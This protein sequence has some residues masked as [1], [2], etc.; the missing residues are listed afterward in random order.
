MN[1]A[2]AGSDD[3]LPVLLLHGFPF[4][5]RMWQPQL[6]AL[7]HSFRLIAPDTRGSG[8]SET[9]DAEYTMELL[10]D[11]VLAILDALGI[12]RAVGCGLSMGGYVLLRALERAPE[13]FTGAVLCDTK[14]SAD[15]DEG[16]QAR[17]S[18][19]GLIRQRGLEHFAEELLP[20]VMA[21][22]TLDCRPEL[23][24]GVRSMIL[25]N[26]EEGIIGLQ[27]AMTGRTDTTP[28]LEELSIPCLIVVG[29]HDELT[30]PDVARSMA[31]RIT[32]AF[33]VQI[34]GAGHLS[35]LEDPEAFNQA[36]TE[37]LERV[38]AL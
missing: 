28:V 23:V 35:N 17:A 38:S 3:R 14:S 8:E 25:A 15:T 18:S 19:I 13:R 24:A 33:V 30:P 36:L 27:R 10:V 20:R 12:E 29:E 4:S 6:Q 26:P 22:G 1:V 9:G 34:P 7:R 16:K 21:H 5:H 32:D 31:Q 37:F 11:D 2:V